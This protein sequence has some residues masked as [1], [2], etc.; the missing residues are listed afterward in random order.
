VSDKELARNED[1]GRWE[2]NRETKE[3]SGAGPKNVRHLLPGNLER[4]PRANPST[5]F[6][7]LLH[8]RHGRHLSPSLLQALLVGAGAEVRVPAAKVEE[9]AQVGADVHCGSVIA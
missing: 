5:R 7:A 3:T 9:E 4:V 8:R 1:G 2:N 6:A